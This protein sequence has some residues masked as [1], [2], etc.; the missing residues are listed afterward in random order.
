MKKALT[1]LLK[2][3][4][5]LLLLVA[6]A[7][8]FFSVS[9][10]FRFSHPCVFS[11]PDI[12]NPYDSLPASVEWKRANFHTH[13]RVDNILNEC[14]GYPAEVYGDY[15]K[16]GYDVL[17]FS[18]HNLLT[19]HPFAPDLQI[20]VYEH[21]YGLFKFHKL[22]F[23]ASDVKHFDHLLPFLVSQKQWQLDLLAKDADFLVLNHPD[24]TLGMT[25]RTMRLL[26]GYRLIEADCGV[27]TDLLRWDEALSA[28]HYS[29]CLVNDDC[30]NS[31]DHR[32]VGRR[33]SWLFSPSAKYEDLRR[34]LTGGCF[35]S[36]RVPDYGDGDWNEK[37]ARNDALPQIESIGLKGDTIYMK[38][39]APARIEARGQDH[40][41]L[42][43]VR[44]E[45]F[46]RSLG[47]DEPY[48]R[49]VAYF[50][51]GVVIYTNAFARY[52]SALTATPYA[53]SPHEINWL[54]TLLFNV[55]LLAAVVMLWLCLR[56]LWMPHKKL[57][58]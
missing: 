58:S 17:A 20:D 49:L 11:G 1:I 40:A 45:S 18:N 34:T 47:T 57:K 4:A 30:H 21:G 2:L 14:P 5:T 7:I 42:A 32:K 16:L 33:C 27:S 22:V 23:G 38:L 28:G 35:Y 50:D 39:S 36:M 8:C 25:P 54:L 26:S 24:R 10:V 44:G 15:M 43:E 52:D 9:P 13:T 29:H 55:A 31:A 51:D 41:L 37:Y 46:S 12:Y 19:R 6:V 53:E 3:S 48:M 56:R